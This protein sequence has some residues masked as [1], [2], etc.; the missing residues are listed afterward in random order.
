MESCDALACQICFEMCKPP[1][2]Q[3]NRGHLVCTLCLSKMKSDDNTNTCP[4]CKW[5]RVMIRC[6]PLE[7]TVA[8]VYPNTTLICD[9]AGCG[10]RVAYSDYT[11][12]LGSCPHRPV[13]CFCSKMIP[14]SQLEEHF[15]HC[16]RCKFVDQSNGN[17]GANGLRLVL[18]RC[19][20]EVYCIKNAS[21]WLFFRHMKDNNSLSVASWY[22][23]HKETV[24]NLLSPKGGRMSIVLPATNLRHIMDDKESW[25]HLL[26]GKSQKRI[27]TFSKDDKESY[28]KIASWTQ[29]KWNSSW[30][31][32]SV[33]MITYKTFKI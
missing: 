32:S 19:N 26:H 2:L 29:L 15:K 6:L 4:T 21:G 22:H 10:Q 13:R 9:H 18:R 12:H 8:T 30:D 3:C 7:K 23:E 17:H 11:E 28:N 25:H 1:L 5:K 31:N 20:V 14:P 16:R 24:I 33:L 27:W